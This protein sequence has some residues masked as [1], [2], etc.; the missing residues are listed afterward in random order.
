MSTELIAIRGID[1]I[2]SVAQAKPLTGPRFADTNSAAVLL[3]NGILRCLMIA[4]LTLFS[5][6]CISHFILQS[7]E[8]VGVSM[9]PTLHNA[10]H[11][12]VNRCS[13]YLRAPARGDVVVIKDPTDGKYSVKRI[14]GVAGE[15]LYFKD[16]HVFVNGRRL[17]EPYLD[18]GTQ[19]FPSEKAQELITCGKNQY[20]VL[21]DN[22]NNSLDSRCYGAV[23]R[24]NI[25]GAIM[26]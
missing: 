21:G 5:Y 14:I 3:V 8:V 4:A 6:F 17:E 9:V 15:S 13:F 7:V 24:Q 23:P 20:F 25:L 22:R 18:P 2:Q 11:Y 16:G 1:R 10:D 26:Q 12:F 19:T